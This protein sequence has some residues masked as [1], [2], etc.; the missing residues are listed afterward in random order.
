MY[1][2]KSH[3]N[4]Y[5]N[6]F[7][8]FCNLSMYLNFIIINSIFLKKNKSLLVFFL[9]V[10]LLKYFWKIIWALSKQKPSD[11]R[12]VKKVSKLFKQLQQDNQE[13]KT[14]WEKFRFLGGSGTCLKIKIILKEFADSER[15]IYS[16]SFFNIPVISTREV[17]IIYM[18]L[19][20]PQDLLLLEIQRNYLC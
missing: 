6:L 17:H 8:Y 11:K 3:N 7:F 14:L 16:L 15:T 1:K 19:P 20:A 4:L 9:I 10:H 18:Q 13:R 5:Y 12:G 2:D